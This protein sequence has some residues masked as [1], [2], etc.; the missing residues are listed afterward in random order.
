ML[1]A[2][3]IRKSRKERRSEILAAALK[4]FLKKGYRQT[5]MEDIINETTLSKG[6]VYYH[7][8]ST[9]EI[10]FAI[11]HEN[12]QEKI[13]FMKEM[14]KSAAD[15]KNFTTR[16][17]NHLTERVFEKSEKRQLYLMGVCE[18]FADQ[19]F[20]ECLNKLEKTYVKSLAKHFQSI[21]GGNDIQKIEKKLLFLGKIYHSLVISCNLFKQEEL[22][23]KNKAYIT[24]LFAE[25]LADV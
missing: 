4:V 24:N 12:S 8:G 9:K 7:F 17:A 6:G 23:Q 3:F 19:E 1:M 21:F 13:D 11:F 22:Y 10:F 16:L 20:L 2:K 14:K 15:Q 18:S 5:T 25:I